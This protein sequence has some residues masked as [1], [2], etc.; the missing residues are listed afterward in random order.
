M[1]SF[2]THISLPFV[3]YINAPTA[4]LFNTAEG[5]TVCFHSGLFLQSVWRPRVLGW[6]SNN[7]IFPWQADSQLWITTRDWLIHLSMDLAVTCGGENG[8]NG[9]HVA[10]FSE[11][12]AFACHFVAP[13]PPPTNVKWQAIQL[14]IHYTADTV[15]YLE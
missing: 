13:H 11:D 2:K 7:P 15:N 14:A 3:S 10:V 8:T 6:P 1:H 12:V 5:W 9:S 4:H